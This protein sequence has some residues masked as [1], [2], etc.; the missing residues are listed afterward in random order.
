M[1]LTERNRAV[2]TG[3]FPLLRENSEDIC[4]RMYDL[5]FRKYPHTRTLF[6]RSRSKHPDLLTSTLQDFAEHDFR[7]DAGMRKELSRIARAHLKQGGVKESYFPLMRECLLQAM[8]DVLFEEFTPEIRRA[9]DEAYN[10][11]SSEL[12]NETSSII[13]PV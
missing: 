5:F 3:S 11:L 7:I 6:A 13:E 9:W 8:E 10:L 4:Y 2:L 12:I 1:Q